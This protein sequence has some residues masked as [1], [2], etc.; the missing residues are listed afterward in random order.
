MVVIFLIFIVPSLLSES[1]LLELVS[2][3]HAD[4]AISWPNTFHNM[5]PIVKRHLA[6]IAIDG[7]YVMQ[8]VLITTNGYCILCN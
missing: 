4:V 3:V 7:Y 6:L 5:W 8:L 1:Y 2:I